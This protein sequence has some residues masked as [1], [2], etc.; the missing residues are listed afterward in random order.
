MFAI[1]TMVHA[2]LVTLLLA[3]PGAQAVVVSEFVPLNLQADSSPVEPGSG[4]AF[5]ETDEVLNPFDSSLGE[6]D[7]VEVSI[8]GTVSHVIN[9]GAYLVPD[10]S[11]GAVPVPYQLQTETFL[12][13][14]GE[15][16]YFS[17]FP[18]LGG[19]QDFQATGAGDTLTGSADF[20]I[21][22]QI[23]AASEALGDDR[24]PDT[25]TY[26]TGLISE[27]RVSGDRIGFLDSEILSDLLL[28][29][30]D[31]DFF[32][33]GFDP[34]NSQPSSLQTTL[35]GTLQVDYHYTPIS[36]IPLPAG[37][38]LFL[39]GLAGVGL[40]GGRRRRTKF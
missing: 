18:D 39:T 1:R 3:A 28:I 23:D 7:R 38:V 40:F 8:S 26:S 22:F 9:A 33:P 32:T 29:V 14:E 2:S 37:L 34:D 20:S 27:P 6:L 21:V 11:G 35:N 16:D 12:G 19:A 25:A 5:A 4:N 30:L 10:P 36:P 17:L 13:F 15:T 31:V 24:A